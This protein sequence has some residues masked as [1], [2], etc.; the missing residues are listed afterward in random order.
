MRPP[1][2][3]MLFLVPLL[4]TAARGA[5]GPW[6][7]KMPDFSWD[8]VP[9]AYHG[10]NYKQFSNASIALLAK[11][12]VITLEKCQG[13][14]SLE[15]PCKG[16]SCLTC[17]EED[18]YAAAGRMVKALNP[19]TKVVAYLHSNKVMPW[20]RIRQTMQNYTDMTYCYNGD[21]VNETACRPANTNEVF[22][23]F[24]KKAS[25]GAW[26]DACIAMTKTG[27]VDGCFADGAMKVEAPIGKDLR[28]GFMAK[29]QAMLRAVQE[30]VPGP[31]ISGSGGGFNPNV[32]ASQVQSFTTKHAGWWGDMMHMNV[33]ASQGHMFEVHGGPLCSNNN[34][35]GPEFQQEYAAFLMF[36][37]KWTYHICNNYIVQYC[38]FHV[39]LGDGIIPN[40]VIV[41]M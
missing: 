29:K 36:A 18:V 5:I 20:Y 26:S 16:F 40:R 3:P 8:T 1:W 15:P 22:Y 41:Q 30:A 14:R 17:C 23:D 12:P 9:V 6:D 7:M 4:A 11:Y 32:A 13:W 33:S 27:Y 35:S 34:V 2:T 25:L 31:V 21:A 37:Q 38:T 19:R 39:S 24:R 10:A 28:A